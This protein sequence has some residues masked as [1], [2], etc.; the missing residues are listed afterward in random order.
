MARELL[1]RI[2]K[3]TVA[4]ENEGDHSMTTSND[5]TQQESVVAVAEIPDED[6]VRKAFGRAENTP[7]LTILQSGS[8]NATLT[9][10]L[11]TGKIP[12]TREDYY[13][14]N[15]SVLGPGNS[16][17][18]WLVSGV[19]WTRHEVHAYIHFLQSGEVRF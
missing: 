7:E 3:L 4:A 10:E 15:V 5:F 17:E 16:M 13:A 14:V 2:R 8:I 9:Y 1:L 12:H 6:T 19:L 11:A 18:N